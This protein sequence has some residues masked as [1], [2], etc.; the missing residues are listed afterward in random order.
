M[1]AAFRTNSSAVQNAHPGLRQA[2]LDDRGGCRGIAVP[3]HPS[4]RGV[5]GEVGR[6]NVK[7]KG[8]AA[9]E[10]AHDLA[11]DFVDMVIE[12]AEGD[13]EASEQTVVREQT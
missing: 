2:V 12:L 5:V 6:L 8:A 7:A 13:I 4:D 10:F 1:G 11:H 9:P 3:G